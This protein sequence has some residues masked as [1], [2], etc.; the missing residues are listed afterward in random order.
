MLCLFLQVLSY[1]LKVVRLLISKGHFDVNERAEPVGVTPLLCAVLCQSGYVLVS[2]SACWMHACKLDLTGECIGLS[3]GCSSFCR[4][5]LL[6]SSSLSAQVHAG[7]LADV[8]HRSTLQK[9]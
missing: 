5:S 2:T 4:S 6:H 1:S 3:A 7:R 8:A 9:A